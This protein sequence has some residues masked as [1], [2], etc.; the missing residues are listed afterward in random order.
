MPPIMMN[1]KYGHTVSVIQGTN[2]IVAC[3]KSD[4]SMVKEG[5]FIVI[6]QDENYYKVS[7]K[8]QFSLNKEVVLLNSTRLKT[9]GHT[10]TDLS[11]DDSISFVNN[12]YF[13]S[14]V[15]VSE[16]GKNYAKG[17]VLTLDGGV[18]K[19]NTIDGID[20][21]AEFEVEEVGEDGEVT[22]IK[23]KNAGIYVELS[24]QIYKCTGG[25]GE[26]V[27]LSINSSL[28]DNRSLEERTITDIQYKD[29]YTEIHINQ[30]LPPK[31]KSGNISVKKWEILL[32]SEY[33]S[34]S[35]YN[36]AYEIIKDFTPHLKMPIIRGDLSS[37]HL[38]YNESITL[39]D[40][41]IKE[42]EEKI[43]ELT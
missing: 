34:H 25:T 26:G 28:S 16:G 31:T 8:R 14:N 22:D 29:G 12:E 43:D 36:A 2:K 10:G 9:T 18:C 20:V 11:L 6:D 23:I 38:L 4:W 1:K 15:V 21:P 27:E 19:F 13:I 5:S 32:D 37:G 42:L 7:E 24:T 35:K 39:L 33:L 17:Q 3:S 41:K 30:A 40:K